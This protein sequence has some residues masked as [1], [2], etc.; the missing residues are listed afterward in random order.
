[1]DAID[2]HAI[3]PVRWE[4]SV[5]KTNFSFRGFA[6]SAGRHSE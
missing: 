6:S 4:Y 1:V 2:R 5:V 3:V